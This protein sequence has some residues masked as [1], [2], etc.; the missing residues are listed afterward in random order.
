M[1]TM[2]VSALDP[3]SGAVL[4]GTIDFS[5]AG[6]L[7]GLVLAV[8]FVVSVFGIL[9]QITPKDA[10]PKAAAPARPV[11]PLDAEHPEAA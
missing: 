6:M 2:P 1:F 8:A 10:T 11:F 3:L 7:I 5:V 9:S 4:D